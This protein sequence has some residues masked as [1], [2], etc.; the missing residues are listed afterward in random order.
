MS[1]GRAT[2]SFPFRASF[3]NRL[4]VGKRSSRPTRKIFPIQKISSPATPI[5]APAIQFSLLREISAGAQQK[6]VCNR[7][8]GL[9]RNPVLLSTAP[10]FV[11]HGMA[12]GPTFPLLFPAI[13]TARE[14]LL[15]HADRARQLRGFAKVHPGSARAR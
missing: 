11:K 2:R 10:G 6:T 14:E 7:A 4:N 5:A 15:R 8:R 1:C 9:T 12:V 13:A 3:I